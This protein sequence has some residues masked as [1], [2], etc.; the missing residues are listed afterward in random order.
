M[1]AENVAEMFGAV[2]VPAPVFNHK[3]RRP[4]RRI[5]IFGRTYYVVSPDDLT[6]MEQAKYELYVGDDGTAN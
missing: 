6:D 1:A 4:E 5:M 2:V 3:R